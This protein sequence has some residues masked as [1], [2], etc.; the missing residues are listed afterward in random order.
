M[1]FLIIIIAILATV[2]GGLF[3]LKFKDKLH[4]VLGFSAGALIGVAFFD[5]LPESIRLASPQFNTNIV[6]SVIALGFIIY[7]I[8]DRT[9]SI[10]CHEDACHNINH[11][12]HF[13]AGALALHSF[14]DGLAI[15]VAFQA[16]NI[17]GYIVTVA[18]LMHKFSDGINTVGLILKNDGTPKSA[19]KWLIIVALAPALGIAATILFA[20]PIT[21]LGLILAGFC[22]FF[23]YIGASDLLPE[24][25][26]D[27]PTLWTTLATLV[28]IAVVYLAINLTNL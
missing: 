2:F 1:L 11:C 25:H 16:S 28:G 4:L 7:L 10:H 12:G 8:I 20:L 18:I 19:G 24:S 6:A 3:A 23:L 27:H 13:G 14:L 26:H 21:W 22:G 5:L 15:G 17:I 9:L